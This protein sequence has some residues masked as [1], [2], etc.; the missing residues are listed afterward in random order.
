ML[1]GM[2]SKGPLVTLAS[3]A[4]LGGGLWAVNVHRTPDQQAPRPAAVVIAA[5]SPVPPAPPAADPFPATANFAGK[6]PTATGTIT[7]EITVTGTEAVAY[8][9]D[10]KAIEAWLRGSAR[11]GALTLTSKGATSTLTGEHHGTAVTGSLRI[12]EKS[13][14]FTASAV[15]RVQGTSNAP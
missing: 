8:A 3:V 1:E 15:D 14:Y 10:G 6:I 7:L 13:W 12:G 9:C 2:K 5:P 4:V 11:A